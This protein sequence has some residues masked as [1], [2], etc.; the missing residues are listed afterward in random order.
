MKPKV[1]KPR[2]FAA[3]SPEKA[4]EVRRKGGKRIHELGRA[5]EYT[6]AEA[7][8]AGRKGGTSV[9]QDRAHMVEIGRR[10]GSVKKSIDHL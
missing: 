7:K 5:H 6:S 2:G 9:S 10:G 3:M 1:K 8:E 4:R